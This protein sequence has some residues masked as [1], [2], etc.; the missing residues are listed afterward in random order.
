MLTLFL[1]LLCSA[2]AQ[3]PPCTT[4]SSCSGPAPDGLGQ[5]GVCTRVRELT[6]QCASIAQGSQACVQYAR[7]GTPFLPYGSYGAGTK[8]TA[9][10]FRLQTCQ[11]SSP[12]RLFDQDF[13]N[14]DFPYRVLEDFGPGN[15]AGLQLMSQDSSSTYAVP[16]NELYKG[17]FLF[18]LDMSNSVLP[19][20]T[21]ASLDALYSQIA[22]IMDNSLNVQYEASGTQPFEFAIFAFAG[23]RRLLQLT[24][25]SAFTDGAAAVLSTNSVG[26]PFSTDWLPQRPYP[27]ADDSSAFYW[28]VPEAIR[29][30]QDRSA[31][32]K[33]ADLLPNQLNCLVV[34]SDGFDTAGFAPTGATSPQ[35]PYES[36]VSAVN[37][38]ASASQ[39]VR[40]L[41]V[42][43]TTSNSDVGTAAATAA[44]N[45]MSSQVNSAEVTG[46]AGISSA[47]T[48]RYTNF[49]SA[50]P[51][52]GLL[53]G[54]TLM[55]LS[56]CPAYRGA[57]PATGLNLNAQSALSASPA[58]T[59]AATALPYPAPP[60]GRCGDP[61]S[62]T[63]PPPT[64][65]PDPCDPVFPIT[66]TPTAAVTYPSACQFFG[67]SACGRTSTQ[68]DIGV[69]LD[70]PCA[71]ALPRRSPNKYS[72]AASLTPAPPARTHTPPPPPPHAH[73]TPLRPLPRKRPPHA[74]AYSGQ[75]GL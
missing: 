46:F 41:T 67:G 15:Y 43:P 28:A 32:G 18:L 11:G 13:S 4:S 17:R 71:C 30:L 54:N 64:P 56:F 74:H 23:E 19:F 42:V 16:V 48:T 72:R 57:G 3:P 68:T 22:G 31:A 7:P 35:N 21:P 20:L 60:N 66:P 53:N 2:A 73:Y 5:P 65:T 49:L 27:F 45:A 62:P 55:M 40:F 1:A 37:A 75:H 36:F 14:P 34:L 33:A 47:A 6:T 9:S 69:R 52:G 39:V 51:D 58:P 26:Q 44:R 50:L 25:W 63:N 70:C 29:T 59:A 12:L 10:L 8:R 38:A 24:Q 61:F